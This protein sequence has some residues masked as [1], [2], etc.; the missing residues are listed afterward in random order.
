MFLLGLQKETLLIGTNSYC[1]KTKA[2]HIFCINFV[3]GLR[4]SQSILFNHIETE[5]SL[6]LYKVILWDLKVSY[7]RALRA[8]VV[9]VAND[10][11]LQNPA[12]YHHSVSLS[13]F[14]ILKTHSF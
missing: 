11:L 2:N 8:G 6:P 12:F 1:T 13:L 3:N 7:T 4:T 14:G 9:V 5:P 10:L